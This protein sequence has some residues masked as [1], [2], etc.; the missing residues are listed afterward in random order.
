[1][2]RKAVVF[3]NLIGA[4]LIV[5]LFFYLVK[6]ELSLKSD[7]TKYLYSSDIRKN[8]D[9][10]DKEADDTIS[11]VTGKSKKETDSHS[12][13]KTAKQ[14]SKTGDKRSKENSHRIHFYNRPEDILNRGRHNRVK[15][16]ERD[17]E[18]GSPS[19]DSSPDSSYDNKEHN[20]TKQQ[21]GDTNESNDRNRSSNNN[22]NPYEWAVAWPFGNEKN[23][24]DRNNSNLVS[25]GETI[26]DL[27][28]SV[29]GDLG[30]LVLLRIFKEEKR[31]ELW[32]SVTGEY[33]LLKSYKLTDYSGTLGPKLSGDDG[34]SPEG[35]YTVPDDGLILDSTG[36]YRAELLFPNRFDKEH[37]ISSGYSSIHDKGV[38]MDGFTVRDTDMEEIYE[39]LKSAFENGYK[40]IPVYIY[41]FIMSDDNLDNVKDN[42]WYD[43]W[44]NIKGGYDYFTGSHRTP[45]IDVINGKYV[46]HVL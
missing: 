1:M 21:N 45:A 35:Y 22:Y 10:I 28:E 3:V 24:T 37:N 39:V 26:E 36:H 20:Q 42:P 9:N 33:K 34:Q 14:Y 46:F 23:I 25:D 30:N 29:G 19:S 16:R 38:D 13:T 27:I 41:P 18:S 2:N 4:V 15:N 44:K 17:R 43:F 12:V 40:A 31:L 6:G 11:I 32:M 7:E 8:I 5:A